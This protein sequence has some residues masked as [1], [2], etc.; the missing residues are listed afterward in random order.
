MGAEQFD[1]VHNALE[2]CDRLQ[3]ALERLFNAAPALGHEGTRMVPT[4]DCPA[5]ELARAM[6]EAAVLLGKPK[7]Y[8]KVSA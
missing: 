3:A 1:A 7:P 6:N 5:R 2:R 4:Y 8:P